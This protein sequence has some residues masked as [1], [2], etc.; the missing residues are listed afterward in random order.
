M[1]SLQALLKVSAITINFLLR[2][3]Y[4]VLH[5]P[6]DLEIPVRPLQLSFGEFLL[7]DKLRDHPFGVDG[8]TAHQT[9]LTRCLALLSDSNG[10]RENICDLEYPG[11][12]RQEIDSITIKERFSPALQYACRYWVHHAQQSEI[13]LLDDDQVHVFLQKH[14]LHWFEALSLLNAS[15]IAIDYVGTLQLLPCVSDYLVA[16][17][18]EGMTSNSYMDS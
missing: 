6:A 17:S 15:T 10:L 14:F 13:P 18:K 5:I 8:P 12:L 3:L 7:S 4:S 1:A 11:Q 16:I 9:L 2:P